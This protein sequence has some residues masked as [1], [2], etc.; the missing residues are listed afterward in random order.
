MSVHFA[1]CQHLGHRAIAKYRDFVDGPDQNTDLIALN[2]NQQVR[3]KDVVYVLG[4]AAFTLE[5]LKV[6]DALPGRKILIKGNHD[7]LVSTLDQ[8]QVF[9][10]IHGMLKYKGMWLTHCP[11]H[12]DELRGKTNVHAHVHSKTIMRRD[13]FGRPKIDKRY[14]NASADNLYRNWGKT[15]LT[16]EEVRAYFK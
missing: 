15:I 12:P 16:L 1:G 10:E 7:D 6:F 4:D 9:E 11:I 14:L 5:T 2:W 8:M 13:L 3:K